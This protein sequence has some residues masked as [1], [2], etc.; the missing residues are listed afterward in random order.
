MKKIKVLFALLL[1]VVL[2]FSAYAP[3]AQAADKVKVTFWHAMNG[4][5][6]EELTKLVKAFNE[7]Q[8]KY[9]VEETSQGNYKALQQG[10]MAAAA[11]GDLPTM[12][13]LTASSFSG[14]KSEGL[15]APLDEFL[16]ADNGFTEELKKDI[17]PGF[18]KGVTVEDKIYAL[19]FS[20]SVR[21]MFVNQDMLKQAGKEVPKTW[22]EVKELAA[23]L[24]EKGVDKP[25]LG[26]ENGLSIEV[27]TMARQNG[28]TWVSDDLK[29]VDLTSD[30]AIEPIQFIKDM[31][32]DGSARLAGEDKYMSGPFAAGGSAIYI[33]SSAGL[34]YVVKGVQES[35]IN[36]TTAPVPTF[37]QGKQMT[38]LAGNDLG[39]FEDASDEEKAGAVAFM[40]FLLKAENT[41]TWAS[42]TGYLPITKSGTNSEIWTN[43]VKENP[44]VKAASDELEYGFTDPIYEGSAKAFSDSE[45]ALENIV[46]ND[47]DIKTEMKKLEDLIKGY[48]HL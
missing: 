39:V 22:A 15:L 12:T 4:P 5:H 32:K 18:L 20:K 17:Y 43:Y 27:E 7:S 38:L 30:K 40:S 42:K 10:V 2:A 41:A 29:T 13:Q 11:S 31:V 25:A 14:F 9:E 48:L 33:G 46:V 26:L 6:A 28:A 36:I 35:G 34:P 19:P 37:G 21:L 16:T 23:A 3:S 1:T 44:L 24:K 47:A 8:D 45:L